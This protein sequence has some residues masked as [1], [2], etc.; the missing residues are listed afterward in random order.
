MDSHASRGSVPRL[1]SLQTYFRYSLRGAHQDLTVPHNKTVPLRKT[2]KSTE[3]QDTIKV[4][5]MEQGIGFLHGEGSVGEPTGVRELGPV[6][7]WRVLRRRRRVAVK[8]A[9]GT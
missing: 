9:I 2:T 8:T 6:E 3:R 4:G 7:Y 5:Y 1:M